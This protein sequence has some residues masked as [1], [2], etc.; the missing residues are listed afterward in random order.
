MKN[1]DLKIARIK[2]GKSQHLLSYE[3]GVPQSVLSLFE[4]GFRQPGRED[5]KKIAKAL[6]TSVADIFPNL[7]WKK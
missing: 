5:A 1:I 2:V 6:N 7:I 4:Q 3:T